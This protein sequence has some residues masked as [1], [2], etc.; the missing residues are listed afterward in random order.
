MILAFL[1]FN[2]GGL[3]YLGYKKLFK[4]NNNNNNK[5]NNSSNN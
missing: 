1:V 5:N 3:Y 4:K 2:P